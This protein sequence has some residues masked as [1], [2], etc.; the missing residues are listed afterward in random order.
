[1]AVADIAPENVLVAENVFVPAR[2]AELSTLVT[3]LVD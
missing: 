3:T 2:D 1:L